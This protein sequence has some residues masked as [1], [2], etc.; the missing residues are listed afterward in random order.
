MRERAVAVL[1][2]VTA[3][4]ATGS[5]AFAAFRGNQTAATTLSAGTLQPPT[6]PSVAQGPCASGLST[7]L[8]VSWTPTSSTWADGYEVLGSL[9]PTGPFTTVGTAPGASTTK[10]TVT[11]LAFGTT[12]HY[13][14]KATKG[15]WRSTATAVA[16]RTTLSALCL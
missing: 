14:V 5:V 16:S 15:N 8:V 7:S 10:Y 1:V 4:L 13:V 2:L 9:L 6:N 11:G 12:Y 3:V